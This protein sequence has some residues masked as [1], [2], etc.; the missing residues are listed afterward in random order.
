[1]KIISSAICDI[2]DSSFIGKSNKNGLPIPFQPGKG[3]K[4]K[5]KSFDSILKPVESEPKGTASDEWVLRQTLY[6]GN[7]ISKGA[8]ANT[9]LAKKSLQLQ[10]NSFEIALNMYLCWQ[11]Y[12]DLQAFT[13]INSEKNMEFLLS[14]APVLFHLEK[15][16]SIYGTLLSQSMTSEDN[17]E[18]LFTGVCRGTGVNE[19]ENLL[20]KL[21]KNTRKLLT[22]FEKS[23]EKSHLEN[24]LSDFNSNCKKPNENK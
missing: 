8:L 17:Y 11:A 1:M 15:N 16:P 12:V 23:E 13:D 2:I 24:I 3:L 14:S 7:L 6:R 19:T 20:T 22:E 4:M 21:V 5:K 9:L 10:K 18:S